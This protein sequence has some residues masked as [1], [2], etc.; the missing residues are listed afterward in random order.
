MSFMLYFSS[1]SPSCQK[2]IRRTLQG[3]L[4]FYP[5]HR[6]PRRW[7]VILLFPSRFSETC[8]SVF[9][10]PTRVAYSWEGVSLFLSARSI[11]LHAKL[12]LLSNHIEYVCHGQCAAIF[13]CVLRATTKT[14]INLVSSM[15]FR[16][17]VMNKSQ[18]YDQNFVPFIYV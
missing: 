6:A 15:T 13:F 17:S 10:S 14:A 1:S 12:N 11:H 3:T 7:F 16:V 4:H 18:E 9:P 8:S 5:L 2:R